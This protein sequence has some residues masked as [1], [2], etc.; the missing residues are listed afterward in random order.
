MNMPCTVGARTVV[1]LSARPQAC[2]KIIHPPQHLLQELALDSPDLSRVRLLLKFQG[3][4]RRELNGLRFEV[5]RPPAPSEIILE[6]HLF[7]E[8][9]AEIGAKNATTAPIARGV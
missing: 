9:G 6:L 2:T 3:F 4:Q 1:G 8:I 5:C 7:H